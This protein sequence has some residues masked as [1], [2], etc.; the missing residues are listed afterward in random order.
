MTKVQNLN[1]Q[2]LATT[3]LFIIRQMQIDF[4]IRKLQI[5]TKYLKLQE[6]YLN[7]KGNTSVLNKLENDMNNFS[8][9]LYDLD[10]AVEALKTN[11]T[12]VLK[13]FVN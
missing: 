9:M 13:T 2:C 5:L 8:I 12:D 1:V 6:R 7:F 4:D 11:E 10:N 3:N